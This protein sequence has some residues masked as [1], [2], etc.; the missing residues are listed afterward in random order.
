MAV[1]FSNTKIRVPQGFRNL[2]EGFTREVLRNQPDDIIIFG[3]R[4]FQ[5]LLNARNGKQN[6]NIVAVVFNRLN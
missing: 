4:Y 3:A 1:P 6:K 2:L 5:F